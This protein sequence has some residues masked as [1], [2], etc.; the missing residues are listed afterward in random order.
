METWQ[1]AFALRN[2][3]PEWVR[4]VKKKF[5]EWATKSRSVG[6]DMAWLFV[7][8]VFVIFPGL[9]QTHDLAS[10]E[11]R[12]AEIIRE[13]VERQDYLIPQVVGEPYYDKPTI[14]HLPAG[15]IAH[16]SGQQSL[17]IARRN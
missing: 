10:R 17:F 6:G 14:M 11:L 3:A 2:A 7:I 9:W 13:M 15:W 5:I 4:G 8:S 12:H 1:N 16:V